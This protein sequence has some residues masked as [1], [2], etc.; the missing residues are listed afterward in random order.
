MSFDE[1]I[2]S[3]L[4]ALILNYLGLMSMRF[5]QFIYIGFC[6]CLGVACI[7]S[8][9]MSGDITGFDFGLFICIVIVFDHIFSLI[10][11]K[12]ATM[13]EKEE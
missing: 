7:I 5:K 6:V 4:F 3:I 9:K 1:I 8:N 2:T 10:I 13:N 12:I 11:N